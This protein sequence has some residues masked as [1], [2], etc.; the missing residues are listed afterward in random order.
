LRWKICG[1]S[2]RDANLQ[3]RPAGGGIPVARGTARRDLGRAPAVREATCRRPGAMGDHRLSG[4][5]PR[6]EGRV[7]D[8]LCRWGSEVWGAALL[9]VPNIDTACG[10]HEGA[11]GGG[12]RWGHTARSCPPQGGGWSRSPSSS[13][14]GTRRLRPGPG[15]I[16][17]T[18]APPCLRRGGREGGKAPDV[19]AGAWRLRKIG[20]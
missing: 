2:P 10:R 12:E 17:I 3:Y 19:T 8:A 7:G 11:E 15:A 20:Y 5:D 18:G 1:R 16:Q 6:K 9:G 14:T 4:R 13:R